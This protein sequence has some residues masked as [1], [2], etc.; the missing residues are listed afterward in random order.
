MADRCGPHGG[1][2]RWADGALGGFELKEG[3]PPGDV[4]LLATFGRPEFGGPIGRNRPGPRRRV[5][6]QTS[7]LSSW[8]YRGCANGVPERG[9]AGR[10]RM[11]R[12]GMRWAL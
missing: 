8:G 4:T 6:T 11:T 9:G 2:A 3:P 7:I 12:G 10:W 5:T 1:C